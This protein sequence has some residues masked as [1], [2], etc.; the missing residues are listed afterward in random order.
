MAR[1][2]G[3]PLATLSLTVGRLAAKNGS[4]AKRSTCSKSI[5]YITTAIPKTEKQ[6]EI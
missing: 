6:H 5:D 3:Q 2:E 1:D 4:L